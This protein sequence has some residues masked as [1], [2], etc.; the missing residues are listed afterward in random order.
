M[1]ILK[2]L[3]IYSKN[4]NKKKPKIYTTLLFIDTVTFVYSIYAVKPV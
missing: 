2:Y 1:L 3:F 4:N